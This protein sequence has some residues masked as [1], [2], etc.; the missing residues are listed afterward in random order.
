M[1][2]I[3]NEGMLGLIAVIAGFLVETNA[4]VSSSGVLPEG[5]TASYCCTYQKGQL[6]A[7]HTAT[8][9]LSGWNDVEIQSI[10]LSM[11]SNKSAGAGSLEM[12]VDG[13]NVWAI[14]NADFASDTWHGSYSSDYVPVVRTFSPPI[15]TS[16]G[17]ISISI[18]ASKNSLYIESYEIA[19]ERAAAR[20]YK[21]T[22]SVGDDTPFLSLT[23]SAVGSGIILPEL[24]DEDG[25]WF[26]GWCT[27]P[28]QT[29]TQMPV[30]LPAGELYY[31]HADTRLWAVY[32]DYLAPETFHYQRTDAQS[33]YYMMAY[34][35]LNRAM[36]GEV[37]TST[38][39]IPAEQI[40]LS[41]DDG[42][43][44]YR[45]FEGNNDWVYY[46]DF[47]AD[48]TASIVH[49]G[50]G[51]HIG[52]DSAK[53]VITTDNVRWRYRLLADSTLA[54]FVPEK[55]G[56]VSLLW[57][58]FKA[59]NTWVGQLIKGIDETKLV[60]QTLLYEVSLQPNF[61][62]YTSYPNSTAISNVQAHTSSENIVQLG[63]YQLH[64]Q[65]GKK[66]IKLCY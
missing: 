47:S 25:W 10:R 49:V 55:E 20:P 66:Q 46:I 35:I 30:L 3:C 15:Q 59:D 52:Y 65:D 11:K 36:A 24:Q 26:V 12:C 13:R 42:V 45:H 9:T 39:T 31:P 7:G 23:E 51:T 64:I 40:S 16:D 60:N 29:T 53:Q 61:I 48:S 56:Y 43:W 21:V 22:F 32:S 58:T 41:S 5:A 28:V 33:G 37:N 19:Y 34:P 8:L 44:Y 27:T 14:A 50:S 4:K 62:Y 6:T 54:F 18:S 2:T 1:W 38:H 17:N 63:I 57:V